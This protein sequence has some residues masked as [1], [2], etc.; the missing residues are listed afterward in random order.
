MQKQGASRETTW[1]YHERQDALLCGQHA[2]N[3]LVQSQLFSPDSLADIALQLDQVELDLM[4]NNNEG[5]INSKEYIQR[6][7]EGSLNV[8]DSGN[9]S[10]EVLRTALMNKCELTLS[11]VKQESIRALD[12]T[13]FEGFICNRESHWIAIRKINDKFW[14][15]NSVIDKPQMISHFR[16]AA[17]LESLQHEGYSVFCVVEIG[18]L[19]SICKDERDR[20]E[21]GL[22]KFWWKESDLLSGTAGKKSSAMEDPWNNV[23]GNGMRLDGKST[24]SEHSTAWLENKTFTEGMTEAQMMEVAM[25]MSLQQAE[26][27]QPNVKLQNL[28]DEPSPNAAGVLRIQFRLP[29]GRKKERRF[30]K[31][32]QVLL[33]YAYVDKEC[34]SD[35]RLELRAGFPPRELSSLMTETLESCKLAGECIQCR[36]I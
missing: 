17:E 3:N 36:Q 10:I 22:S 19:P 34:P 26:S 33:L 15:L 35:K 32:D 29:D 27:T 20:E 30:M 8:D 25:Q 16:L 2:L 12:I 11:N 4:S 5:G 9:Y 13:E 31:D 24:T 28:S 1:I 23:T 21:R 6:V 18:S 7:A 14:N